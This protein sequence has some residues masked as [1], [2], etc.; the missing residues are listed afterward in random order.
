MV[1]C[2]WSYAGAAARHGLRLGT[3]DDIAAAVEWLIS[4]AAS[5]VNATDLLV[6]GGVVATM[7]WNAASAR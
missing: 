6:D 2:Q 1:I 5:F 3:P 7:R 4:P